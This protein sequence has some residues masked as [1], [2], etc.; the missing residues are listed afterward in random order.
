MCGERK[1]VREYFN[2]NKLSEKSTH[3]LNFNVAPTI[4]EK[5]GQFWPV[6]LP[7]LCSI[8]LLLNILDRSNLFNLFSLRVS[9]E[10]PKLPSFSLSSWLAFVHMYDHRQG[11]CYHTKEPDVAT[12]DVL[13]VCVAVYLF[14][15]EMSKFGSHR[16]QFPPIQLLLPVYVPCHRL[17]PYCIRYSYAIMLY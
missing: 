9:S 10:F 6:N 11:R 14:N 3:E 7:P 4:W 17:Q 2:V 8:F 15:S 12:N 1:G 16:T 13:Y 5:L